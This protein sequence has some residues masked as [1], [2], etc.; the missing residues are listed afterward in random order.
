MKIGLAI[1]ALA[2]CGAVMG[3]EV[4]KG[5]GE[6]GTDAAARITFGSNFVADPC[7]TCKYNSNPL[8][9]YF[10][11]GRDNC[12]SPG[13][14]QSV[15]VPFIAAA[16]GIPN[17]ILTSIILNDPA[18][19][20]TN[21][22]TLGL[23]TDTCGDGPGTL[24]AQADAT[25][26]GAACE[27]TIAKLTA[28][29]AITQGTKYWI[30]ATTTAAQTGLDSRWYASNNALYAFDLGEGWQA[31]NGTTPAFAIQ[32]PGTISDKAATAAA[33][34]AFGG[35]LFVDPCTGCNYDSASGGFDVRGSE[36]CTSPGQTAS[37]AVP[38]VAQRS[39][40]PKRISAA[41]ILH[42]PRSCPANK[43][44]LS[45]YSDKNCAGVPD[46]PL[47]SA[48][49]T[50]PLTPC[51]LAVAKLRSSPSLV[52]GQKYWAVATTTPEQAG[53]DATWYASNSGQYAVDLGIGWIQ[54][55]TGT[56]AFLVE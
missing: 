21:T 24:L 16:D 12:T 20:P 28:A 4:S 33:H 8:S 56:P 25:V 9:G 50:V 1:L 22:V 44:T 40:V 49:A 3:Q 36:N 35:N 11:W 41:I 32:G 51:E 14:L 37:L 15:A 39:G 18:N 45:L 54:S 5:R 43:V 7:Q 38:F 52:K 27:L 19:C 2:A 6:I 17:R 10:V 47:V 42:N 26:A 34:P 46:T 48:K 55:S 53:L 13:D 31:S 29:P 30:T 23:Y